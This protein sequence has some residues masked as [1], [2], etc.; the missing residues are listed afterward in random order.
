MTK[1]TI[2]LVF[3]CWGVFADN[4]TLSKDS[5]V[6]PSMHMSGWPHDS[7]TLKNT[8]PGQ[9]WLDSAILTITLMDT[10]KAGISLP[11]DGLEVEWSEYHGGKFVKSPYWKLQHITNNDYFL[12]KGTSVIE[13]P[14]LL[15]ASG[16]SIQIANMQIG[17]NFWGDVPHYPEN[18]KG[19]LRLYFNNGQTVSL[20]LHAYNA[21]TS[22]RQGTSFFSP[23]ISGALRKT[24]HLVNGRQLSTGTMKSNCKKVWNVVF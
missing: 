24:N 19:T 5:L 7:V 17:G 15:E 13:N 12:T 2:I 22:I 18:F 20:T 1:S 6:L 11:R 14:L 16:D 21:A 23:K 8:G 9:V 3:L 4:I 10:G